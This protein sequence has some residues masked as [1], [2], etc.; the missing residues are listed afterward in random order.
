[1]HNQT[2]NSTGFRAANV[3]DMNGFQVTLDSA[4]DRRTE[5]TVEACGGIRDPGQMWMWDMNSLQFTNGFSFI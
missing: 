4:V 3:P 2:S 1:M 5:N